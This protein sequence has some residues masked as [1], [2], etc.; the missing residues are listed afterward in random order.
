MNSKLES[1]KDESFLHATWTREIKFL[2]PYILWR[3]DT[4]KNLL[5][6]EELYLGLG[7]IWWDSSTFSYS[8]A[9]WHREHVE[10]VQYDLWAKATRR[11]LTSWLDAIDAL[12]E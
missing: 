5:R 9:D 8:R 6:R 2:T 10:L 4:H 12:G 7:L 1:E 11:V 3:N